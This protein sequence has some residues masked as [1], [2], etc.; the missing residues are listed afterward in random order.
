MLINMHNLY[1]THAN[2]LIKSTTLM[3]PMLILKYDVCE[4]PINYVLMA[5]I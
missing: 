1:G 3:D 2:I 5:H 4:T